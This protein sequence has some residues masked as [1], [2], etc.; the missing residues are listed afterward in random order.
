MR[1]R[2]KSGLL[3]RVA[4]RTIF[5]LDAYFL[6]ASA[7]LELQKNWNEFAATSPQSALGTCFDD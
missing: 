1:N 3:A 5:R 4:L 2:V 6:L 7:V